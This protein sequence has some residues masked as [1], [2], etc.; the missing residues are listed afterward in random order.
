MNYV[1]S[2]L[3][4]GSQKS[5]YVKSKISQKNQQK[6]NNWSSNFK[7]QERDLFQLKSQT[8]LVKQSRPD[9]MHIYN[10][11]NF[12]FLTSRTIMSNITID[13][14]PLVVYPR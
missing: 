12:N 9:K 7:S 13:L 3:N 6:I 2:Q 8:D 11:V 1:C 14:V 5:Q 10:L 4:K